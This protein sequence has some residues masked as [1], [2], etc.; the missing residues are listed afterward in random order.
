MHALKRQSNCLVTSPSASVSEVQ[1]VHCVQALGSTAASP[2]LD[3]ALMAPLD[4]QAGLGMAAAILSCTATAASGRL[5]IRSLATL[6]GHPALALG[7]QPSTSGRLHLVGKTGQ[8]SAAS[9][10]LPAVPQTLPIGAASCGGPLGL[11]FLLG[12]MRAS[13]GAGARVEPGFGR[14]VACLLLSPEPGGRPGG[15]AVH[16]AALDASTHT[17]AAL[18]GGTGTPPDSQYPMVSLMHSTVALDAKL[19]LLVSA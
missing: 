13:H 7:Y 12:P 8:L 2:L 19:S 16:P 1:C 11:E 9:P 3:V 14:A 4:L 10:L 15:Y 6:P 18:A 17:A 5:E